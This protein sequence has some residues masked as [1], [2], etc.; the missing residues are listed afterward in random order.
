MADSS[1]DP[2]WTVPMRRFLPEHD[3]NPRN[4]VVRRTPTSVEEWKASVERS[5]ELVEAHM[6]GIER[7]IM[8]GAKAGG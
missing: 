7:R 4:D 8:T 6:D 1:Q 5:I 2:P 3:R